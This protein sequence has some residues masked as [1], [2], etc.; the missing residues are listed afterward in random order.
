MRDGRVALVRPLRPAEDVPLLVEM[1]MQQIIAYCTDRGFSS[2]LG[3]VLRQNQ[4]MRGLA[5]RL[6]FVGRPFDDEDMVMVALPLPGKEGRSP[7]GR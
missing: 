3:I 4:G 2:L 6:G 7:A 1:L 5:S